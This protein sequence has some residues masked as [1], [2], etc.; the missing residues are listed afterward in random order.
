M[1]DLNQELNRWRGRLADQAGVG[2]ADLEEL[3]DHLRE[4]MGDLRGKGLSEEEAFLVASRRLGEPEDLGSEFAIADPD[5][6]RRFRL[7]WMVVGILAAVLLWLASGL[8]ATPLV[9]GILLVLGGQQMSITGSVVV[10]VLTRLLLVVLGLRVIWKMLAS[11]GSSRRI[12]SLGPGKVFAVALVLATLVML[13]RLAPAIFLT[14]GPFYHGGHHWLA[15]YQ[16][17]GL[18]LTFIVPALLLVGLWKLLRR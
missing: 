10:I 8:V 3:E 13:T 9:G 17:A 1:F 4:S 11:D 2:P 7:R 6:R 18:V 12:G 16:F 14:R 5:N 15:A